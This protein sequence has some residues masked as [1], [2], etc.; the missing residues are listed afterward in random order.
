MA[1]KKRGTK[2]SAA[3]KEQ[4]RERIEESR[5]NAAAM[6]RNVVA[7][8]G[9]KKS[10]AGLRIGAILLWVLG[11][12]LEIAAI[13]VLNGTI[14][15]VELF[16]KDSADLPMYCMIALI[17][18]DLIAVIIGSQL[19]KKANRINPASEKNKFGFWLWNNMGVIAAVLCFAPLIVLF[20]TNKNLE[21]KHKVILT[22]VAAIA[23][24]IAGVASYD[25]DPVSQEDMEAA[26][27]NAATY[28]DGVVFYTEHGSKFHYFADCQHIQAS[29]DNDNVYEGTVEDA[30]ADGYEEL[31]KTCA[32]KAG[33]PAE[34]EDADAAA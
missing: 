26:A 15:V 2:V 21:K 23:L 30:W 25:F 17:V 11:L 20:L 13:L 6:G 7:A 33:Q 34:T 9:E 18:L 29:L 8:P 5:Q 27:A 16:K 1:S 4:I 31:C 32:R 19:W 28:N 14:D 12:G 22:V 3:D 10:T 24:M